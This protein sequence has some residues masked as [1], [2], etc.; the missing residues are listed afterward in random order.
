MHPKE[1]ITSHTRD[2]HGTLS[3]TPPFAGKSPAVFQPE[4][5]SD[6]ASPRASSRMQPRTVDR[7]GSAA[8]RRCDCRATRAQS[9]RQTLGAAGQPVIA[10]MRVGVAGV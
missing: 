6:W 8:F 5:A 4:T 3:Q 7:C 9:S 10:L 2:A 1:L